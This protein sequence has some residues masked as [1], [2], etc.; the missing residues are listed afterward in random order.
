MNKM[1]FFLTGVENTNK[2]AELMLYAILKEI[3]QKAP[4]SIIYVEGNRI[5]GGAKTVN[6]TLQFITLDSWKTK[7]I[8]ILR[9]N[10]ILRKLHLAPISFYPTIPQIDYLIDGS[11]LLFSDQIMKA[12]GIKYRR[13]LFECAKRNHAKIVFLPQCFGPLE[14]D[15]TKESVK[16][17][18]DYADLVFA[19][20]KVS[21]DIVVNSGLANLSKLGLYTDFTASVDGIC[22]SKYAHLNGGICVIPNMQM[23]NKGVLTKEEYMSFILNAINLCRESGNPVYLLNHEG[24]ADER[25]S[26]ECA[27]Q[28][29]SNVEVVTGLNAIETKGIISKAYLV[30]TSRYHG[31]ASALN[32]GVPVLATSWSHKY[33]CLY[34]DYEIENLV[35]PITD[36][37]KCK[38]LICKYLKKEENLIMRKRL[39]DALPA[40]KEQIKQ[41]WSDVWALK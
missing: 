33:Q 19:R 41:M 37:G 34:E 16:L 17:L 32:S 11:G 6:T 12:S 22:P 29:G 38:I 14:R 35:L 13:Y 4:D 2:G 24:K 23:V 27:A 9:V 10:S 30:I 36:F 1:K 28:A 39:H 15:I 5:R 31:L 40:I 26:Y 8:R 18:F 3:E 7:A 20:E 21:Y 25:F